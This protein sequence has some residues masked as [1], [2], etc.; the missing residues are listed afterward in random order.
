MARLFGLWYALALIL[1]LSALSLLRTNDGAVLLMSFAGDAVHMAQIATRMT[2]GDVPGQDFLTPL[3]P[4]AVWPIVWFMREAGW[5]LGLAF[6][7]APVMFCAA[8]MPAVWWFGWTR[9]PAAAALAFGLAVIVL[10]LSFLHGGLKPTVTASMYYNNWGWALSLLAVVAGLT[11]GGRDRRAVAATLG[12]SCALLA[13]IKAPFAV[14][15]VPVL[16]LGLATARR[17]RELAGAAAIGVATLAVLTWPFGGVSYWQGYVG[18]LIFVATAP[19]R[20]SPGADLLT[21][22]VSPQHLPGVLAVLAAALFL[23]QGADNRGAA[24]VLALGAAGVA[25]AQ[26]NWQNDPHWMLGAGLLI[27]VLARGVTV[28]NGFGWHLGGALRWSA[29]VLF[30]LAAP[31]FYAQFQSL[32][33]HRGLDPSG[34]VALIPGDNTLLI[35][36]SAARPPLAARAY[37]VDG[38]ASDTGPFGLTL[39]S[40]EQ[41]RGLAE[42]LRATGRAL[43]ARADTVGR[44]V[45]YADWVNAVWLYS[46]TA[47][48]PG[49]APWYYGGAPGADA[50]ELLVVP[51]CPMGPRIRAM[52]LRE[53]AANGA[54]FE[55]VEET[56]LFTLLRRVPGS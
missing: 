7:Y 10:M 4:A 56:P 29:A 32:L 19:V 54:Q 3:G 37:G 28:Y 33:V 42:T 24:L 6:A 12:V 38:P 49:G 47:R 51:R 20:S 16:V 26:Q 40:C 1:G 17:G 46:N 48:L 27:W 13:L 43:D 36:S 30:A 39:D 31:A 53:L 15:L 35:R 44:S 5:P 18:D 50:V 9:L 14:Y 22:A 55:T 25:T 2:I 45:L 23:R 21:L 41:T 34:Y 52:V 8:M 11:P